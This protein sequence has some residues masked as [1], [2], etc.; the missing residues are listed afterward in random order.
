MEM[1]ARDPRYKMILALLTMLLPAQPLLAGGPYYVAPS[2]NDGNDC[3]API[4]PCLTIQH[5]VDLAP[6]A[7]DKSTII[8][9]PG[10]YGAG[11]D[12]ANSKFVN[13]TGDCNNR[14]AATVSP[15][16][17][18]T[19]FLAQDFSTLGLMCLTIIGNGGKDISTRQFAIADYSQITFR[20]SMSVQV[21]AEE[22]SKIN[23]IGTAEIDGNARYHTVSSGQSCL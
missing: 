20:G 10:N 22:K 15:I 9:A 4:S 21:S 12:V 7:G 23:C 13:I 18:G 3:L 16:S 11:A 19:A 8:L 14:Y 1:I 2:G 6:R 5:A 17:E